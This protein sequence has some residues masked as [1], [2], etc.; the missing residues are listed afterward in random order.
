MLTALTVLHVL[1]EL[2]VEL[3][4]VRQLRRID[5]D[6]VLAERDAQRQ[7]NNF[8]AEALHRKAD[9]VVELTMQLVVQFGELLALAQLQSQLAVQ[10]LQHVAQADREGVVSGRIQLLIQLLHATFQHFLRIGQLGRDL[11][12]GSE[13]GGR[14]GANGAT[15]QDG[16]VGVVQLGLHLAGAVFT[17]QVRDHVPAS[18][19]AE[20]LARHFRV[21]LVEV[22]LVGVDETNHVGLHVPGVD[23]PGEP[24]LE[25]GL[26]VEVDH[27]VRQRGRHTERHALVLRPV[28]C[29]DQCH[30][31]R[32]HVLADPAVQHQLIR[33]SLNARR[34]RGQ[35]V[36]EEDVLGAI[37]LEHHTLVAEVLSQFGAQLGLA[38]SVQFRILEALGLA[39]DV[40][41]LG[42][43]HAGG[44]RGEFAH[45]RPAQG[46]G[47][48]V[49]VRDALEVGRLHQ[50][51]TDVEHDALGVTGDA[52]DYVGLANAGR[53]PQHHRTLRCDRETDQVLGATGRNFLQVEGLLFAHA[54][55]LAV[56]VAWG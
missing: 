11:E 53:T 35:L 14:T 45:R 29:S 20:R 23:S 55:S 39:F 19:R 18:R 1:A 22:V 42:A 3:L 44:S 5:L 2:V 13:G 15:E 52:L 12:V 51:E 21:E 7:H 27:S 47:V 43:V 50:V 9:V 48:L 31:L 8:V 17:Q 4:E 24:A 36:E 37:V 6:L 38:C 40:G 10:L 56:R 25:V 28:A 34:R 30:V 33:S 41:Q 46:L 32:Q 49:E 54:Y 16:E 26:E